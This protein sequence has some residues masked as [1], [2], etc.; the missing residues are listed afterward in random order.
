MVR[1]EREWVEEN[2]VKSDKLDVNGCQVWEKL[3]PGPEDDGGR[4]RDRRELLFEV[5]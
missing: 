2:I 5:K 1:N 3:A 4:S